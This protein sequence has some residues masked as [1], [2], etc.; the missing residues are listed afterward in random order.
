MERIKLFIGSDEREQIGLH[1]FLESLWRH[2]SLPVDLTVLTPKIGEKLGIKSD[3]TNSFSTLRF[4]VPELCNHA[5]HALFL[6]GVDML[7]RADLAEL[8]RMRDK[9][10]V[11]VV[12]HSYQ[13]KHPRKYVGTTLEAANADYERKNWS[14][15]ML[16][17][18]GHWAHFNARG[19]LLS[20]GG[21]YLHRFGWLRDD[22]I[23][24]LPAAWNHL[25]GEQKYNPDA[26]LAHF[27]LGIPGFEHYRRSDYA[28][29]WTEHL[30]AAAKGLQY[31]G[32]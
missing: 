5:G 2:C 15:V 16:L 1:V 11:Q 20:G 10:A 18:C 22:Q 26:K 8:W 7:M 3:G 13:T 12:K 32:R 27:T 29:E 25:V 30:K 14:S 24:E 17:W 23:G 31:L 6:D 19:N 28:Q 4:A 9:S 21:E